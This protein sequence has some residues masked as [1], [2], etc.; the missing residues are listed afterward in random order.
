V[1]RDGADLHL[2]QLEFR[3]LASLLANE[4]KVMTHRRL[5][6]EVWGPGR[7]EHAHYLRIYIGRLRQKIEENPA[8]PK[9]LL[10]ETGVG[11]RFQ[12]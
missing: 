7:T 1:R 4:G 9:Y 11:Y 2:T 6:R 3:L 10:T 5:M 12:T 8:Q